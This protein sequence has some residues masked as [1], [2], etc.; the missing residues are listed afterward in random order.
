MNIDEKQLTLKLCDYIKPDVDYLKYSLPKYA[1][2]NVLGQLFFNRM[3]SVAYGI[4]LENNLLEN[5]NREFRNSLKYSYI[6]NKQ[7]NESFYECVKNLSNLLIDYTDKYAMLK[8]AVL[9]KRY[10]EGYRTSNDIDLL[11]RQEDITIIGDTLIKNGFK[12]GYIKNDVFIEATRTQIIESKMLR[13][14]TVPYILKVDLPY[15]KYLEIDIN[16]S[17]DY[18][19]SKNNDVDLFIKNSCDINLGNF[20]VKTLQKEDFILHLCVHLYKEATTFPWV[21]MKRDMTLY[22]FCDIY[23]YLN[24]MTFIDVNNL[25]IKAKKFRI[26]EICSCVIFWTSQFFE[27]INSYAYIYSKQFLSGSENILNT[28]ISPSDKKTYRYIE[29]NVTERFFN[30]NRMEILEEVNNATT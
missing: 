21:K 2:E 19:N 13:G 5:V 28:V 1:T 18:K 9:C 22:K 7:K 3:S 15:M 27:N 20:K 24:D 23:T 14:E 6:Q 29:K 26:L 12:Q 11:V 4:M 16:F 17:L 30:K 10:P 25:F 8:G